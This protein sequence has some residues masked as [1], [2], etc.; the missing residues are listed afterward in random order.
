M[1]VKLGKGAKRSGTSVVHAA[2]SEAGPVRQVN[3][4]SFFV[5]ELGG[6]YLAVVADGMGGHSTGEVA[7]QKAVE[8][9][10]R[11]LAQS[12]SYPPAALA[13]A[14]QSANLEIFDY[15]ADHP[16]HHGMGTTLTAVFIDDQVGLVGH[17]GDSRLYLVRDESIQQLT[18]DHSWVAERVRQGT[19]TTEE[20]KHHRLR[21]IITNALGALPEVKLDLSHFEVKKGDRLLLCSD[22]VNTLLSDDK[23]LE[24]VQSRPPEE[25]A[26]CL[27]DAANALGSPDN[28]TAVV[29]EVTGV[30]TRQK[31]Y[32]LPPEVRDEARSVT[33]GGTMSG[34]RKVEETF[35][36]RDA[37]SNLKRKTWFPYRFW[38][39]GSL[40]M[41]LLIVTFS[42]WRP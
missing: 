19:L 1:A 28:V 20:A 8:I 7:S 27:V 41:I 29:L 23:L 2:A 21:N 12:R 39:L 26:Q 38:I 13:R 11:E 18:F 34:I 35:P 24:T 15:A 5:G 31:K 4:D 17:V 9:I 6:G 10:R 40:Y 42:L 3:Q 30:E 32:A 36:K 16:E 37:W 25:A 14:V 22:G 33:I